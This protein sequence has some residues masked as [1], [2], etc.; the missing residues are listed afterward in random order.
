MSDFYHCTVKTHS[1]RNAS[2]NHAVRSAAYRSGSLLIDLETKNRY[3]YTRKSEVVYSEIVTPTK[4]PDRFKNRQEL[5]NMVE[6]SENRVDAQLFR[7]IEVGLPKELELKDMVRLIREYVTKTAVKYGM[8]ADFSIHYDEGNPHCHIMLTMRD[9]VGDAFGNKNRT[10]NDK[11]FLKRWREDWATLANKYLV[12]AGYSGELDSR[13]YSDR[14]L[15]KVPT[16][17]EGR[18][19]VG[20]INK[21]KVYG[22]KEHN[23]NVNQF[24]YVRSQKLS[25]QK[26]LASIENLLLEEE[27]ARINNLTVVKTKML[28]SLNKSNLKP[29]NSIDDSLASVYNIVNPIVKQHDNKPAKLVNLNSRILQSV[30]PLVKSDCRDM[31]VYAAP[32]IK[33]NLFGIES[34]LLFNL[35]ENPYEAHCCYS[36]RSLFG[37]DA[38]KEYRDR[39]NVLK[40]VGLNYTWHD[41]Y[42][43]LQRDASS[44]LGAN[45]E[46]WK[47]IAKMTYHEH[48]SSIQDVRNYVPEKYRT[49]FDKKIV[50]EASKSNVL[51]EQPDYAIWKFVQQ[52]EEPRV[53]DVPLTPTKVDKASV[54]VSLTQS[55]VDKP[56]IAEP[57]Q[58][59]PRQHDEAVEVKPFNPY[60]DPYIP[61]KPSNPWGSSSY[62]PW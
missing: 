17:H 29:I 1:R 4:V 21:E 62:G 22:R 24:N 32:E 45:H 25:K 53:Q 39:V 11:K 26:E 40:I 34:A 38:D 15:D 44:E 41:Y 13:S 46:W 60:P 23:A 43:D 37:S 6:Q 27:N 3:N 51:P 57:S 12:E 55:K 8:I 33:K 18:V 42:S 19:G 16:I 36:L 56:S 28:N 48:N 5:W 47:I 20:G 14:G 50:I 54:D 10:W 52:V 35:P 30:K 61:P 9:V 31:V 49:T 7:E 2:T 58:V 59:P